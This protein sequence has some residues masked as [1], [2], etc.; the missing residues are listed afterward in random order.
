MIK[1]IN[2]TFM[3]I[4]GYTDNIHYLYTRERKQWVAPPKD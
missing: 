2:S 3:M 4:K 1:H